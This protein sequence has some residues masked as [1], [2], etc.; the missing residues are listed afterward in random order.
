MTSFN[1]KVLREEY[2]KEEV[3]IRERTAIRIWYAPELNLTLL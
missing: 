1:A 2:K 3:V